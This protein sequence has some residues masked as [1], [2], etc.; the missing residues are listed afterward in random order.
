M[1]LPTELCPRELWVRYSDKP[2]FFA[3]GVTEIQQTVN[4][5]RCCGQAFVPASQSVPKTEYRSFL[6]R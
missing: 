1:A 4:D 5:R 3:S 2:C 6:R